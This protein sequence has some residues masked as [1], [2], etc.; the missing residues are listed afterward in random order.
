MQFRFQT[1]TVLNVGAPRS[2]ISARAHFGMQCG[3]VMFRAIPWN[4]E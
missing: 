1:Q 4:I 3:K 2:S